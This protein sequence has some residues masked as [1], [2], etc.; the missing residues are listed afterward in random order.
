MSRRHLI[1][2]VLVMLFLFSAESSGALMT[3][4]GLNPGD[5]FR[6]VFVTSTTLDA[7]STSIGDYDTFVQ[8]LADA[9]NLTYDGSSL[10]WSALGSTQTVDANSRLNDAIPIYL[11]DG[12][13]VVAAGDNI[14]T[15]GDLKAP[16]NLTETGVTIDEQVWTGTAADGYAV[17]IGTSPPK[18]FLGAAVDVTYGQSGLVASGWVDSNFRP[19]SDQYR[20]YAYSGILEAFEDTPV[21]PEPASM[22]LCLI[23]FAAMYGRRWA[24]RRRKL[25][26]GEGTN[27]S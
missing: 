26:D 23:G 7:S 15:S 10:T 9:A 11:L 5:Q 17:S 1:A 25:V 22:T 24:K 2:P 8:G 21:I 12:T 16:I 20:F 27:L 3:P 19:R 14:W 13:N 4:S 6:F 18:G